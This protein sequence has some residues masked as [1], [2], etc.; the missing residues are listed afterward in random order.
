M[1]LSQGIAGMAEKFLGQNDS[2]N[3]ADSLPVKMGSE[4]FEQ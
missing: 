2:V 3:T 1:K 4:L